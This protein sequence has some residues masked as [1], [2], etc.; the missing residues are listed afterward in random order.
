M[1]V[2]ESYSNK[3]KSVV[4]VREK[5]MTTRN[6]RKLIPE[7]KLISLLTS[8]VVFPI[9]NLLQK[10]VLYEQKKLQLKYQTS[11]IDCSIPSL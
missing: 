9:H 11:L 2:I 5:R 7:Y 3:K 10:M 4:K 8:A 6:T 1:T